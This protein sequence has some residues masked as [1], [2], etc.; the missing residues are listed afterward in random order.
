MKLRQGQLWSLG[1]QH[2]RIVGLERLAVDYKIITNL[3]T[4]EG[5]HHHATKKEFCA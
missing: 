4:N 1:N 2:V 5:T 3:E